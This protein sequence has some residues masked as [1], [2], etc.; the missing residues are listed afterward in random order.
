MVLSNSIY[1]T[2]LSNSIYYTVLSNSIYWKKTQ[3]QAYHSCVDQMVG[4]T[5]L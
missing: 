4:Y 5:T 2:V 3:L 1:Y